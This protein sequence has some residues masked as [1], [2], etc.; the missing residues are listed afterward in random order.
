MEHV[1]TD[2]EEEKVPQL[3]VLEIVTTINQFLAATAL[4]QTYGKILPQ[5][6]VPVI[7]YAVTERPL[8]SLVQLEPVRTKLAETM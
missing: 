8:L 1:K 3:K 6:L 4:L 7:K 2:Q 5:V